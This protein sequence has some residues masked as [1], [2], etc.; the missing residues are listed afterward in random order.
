[1]ICSKTKHHTELDKLKTI[2]L[3]KGYPEDVISSYTGKLASFSG[4]QMFGPQMGPVYLKLPWIGNTPLR[5]ES[6]IKHFSHKIFLC[7]QSSFFIQ[8]WKAHPSTQKEPIP[9]AEKSSFVYEF[10]CRDS[11]YVGRTTKRLGDRIKQH[12]PSNIRRKTVT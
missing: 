9:T 12:I 3:D 1:M 8:Y 7:C 10:T 6:Q 5:F 11:G 4:V 2:F